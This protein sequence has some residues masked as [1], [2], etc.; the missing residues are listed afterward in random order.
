[1]IADLWGLSVTEE[2]KAIAITKGP[3]TIRGFVNNTQAHHPTKAYQALFVNQRPVQQRMLNHA[4]Y[5]AYREWLPVGRHPVYC[6]F[7]DLDPTLVDVNVHPTKRE[8]RISEERAVYDLLYTGIRNLFGNPPIGTVPNLELKPSVGIL[9]TASFNYGSR[10]MSRRED[11]NMVGF[12]T[13][14]A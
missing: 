7:V 12:A 2:L 4:V 9:P 11:G 10:P 8:V 14:M 6:L 13:T 3:C 1:R 5:E